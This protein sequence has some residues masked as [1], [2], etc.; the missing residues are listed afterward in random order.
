M[1]FFS[2]WPRSISCGWAGRRAQRVKTAS[3]SW[4]PLFLVGYVTC[5][6]G[7]V[8]LSTSEGRV[9]WLFASGMAALSSVALLTTPTRVFVEL[10]LPVALVLALDDRRYSKALYGGRCAGGFGHHVCMARRQKDRHCR[11]GWYI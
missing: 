6:A 7:I 1:R 4:K 9:F 2:G 10:L 8:Q 3:S 11:N 5:L